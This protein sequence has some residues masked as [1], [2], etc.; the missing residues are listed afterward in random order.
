[1]KLPLAD[2]N[3][4]LINAA[5]PP[6]T[7][8]ADYFHQLQN[9]A[10]FKCGPF[11][12]Y[13]E[14]ATDGPLPGVCLK[15]GA[16]KSPQNRRPLF[17]G[18]LHCACC[19]GSMTRKI[20]RVGGREYEYYYCQYGRRHGCTRPSMIRAD[21]LSDCLLTVIRCLFFSFGEPTKAP[22]TLERKYLVP[23]IDSIQVLSRHELYISFRFCLPS[24]AEIGDRE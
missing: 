3:R 19:G 14:Y 7:R 5:A 20:S 11:L 8:I 10:C 6:E 4:L 23:L 15:T 2:L 21:H 12:V 18:L 1:M 13:A 17:S 9:P 16:W 22:A 24:F